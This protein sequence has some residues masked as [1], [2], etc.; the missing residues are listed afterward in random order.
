MQRMLTAALLALMAGAAAAYPT[1]LEVDVGSLEVTA[2]VISDGRLAVVR[3]T[4][5][6]EFAVRCDAVFRNG[7]EIGRTRRAIIEPA[8]TGALTWMPRREVVRLRVELSCEP[9]D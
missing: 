9:Q 2:Q 4:N 5:R 3:V 1:D 7:P 8:D 6:E